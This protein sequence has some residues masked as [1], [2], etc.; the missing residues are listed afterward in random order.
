V[1]SRLTITAE[2]EDRWVPQFLGLLKTMEDYGQVGMS[3]TV[4]IYADGDGDF[5]PKF[6]WD[7]TVET[8]EPHMNND[9]NVFF[10][11]G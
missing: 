6:H 10:D 4:S 9:G 11:A 5:H 2:M 3:R 1:K 8:A 7:V